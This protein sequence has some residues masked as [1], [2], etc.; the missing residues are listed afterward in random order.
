MSR[1]S[2]AHVYAIM[3]PSYF[4]FSSPFVSLYETSSIFPLLGLD[5]CGES[6]SSFPS[7]RF[8]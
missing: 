6:F 1:S 7:G 4:S 8:G 5:K 2:C 3:I